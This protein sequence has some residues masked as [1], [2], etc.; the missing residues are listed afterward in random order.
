MEHEE[1]GP[2]GPGGGGTDIN[3][4]HQTPLS[5]RIDLKGEEMHNNTL[6]SLSLNYEIV[7]IFITF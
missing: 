3:L 4:T 6:I 1:K 2:G 5:I 7:Q